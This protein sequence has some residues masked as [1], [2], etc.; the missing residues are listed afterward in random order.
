LWVIGYMLF[1]VWS[2]PGSRM[3]L[4][5]MLCILF[6]HLKYVHNRCSERVWF[7][8][9][10]WAL[11]RSYTEL[12]KPCVSDRRTWVH[13][14]DNQQSLVDAFSSCGNASLYKLH[15]QYYKRDPLR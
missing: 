8:L 6:F 3:Y 15:V 5:R 14:R 4:W 10:S 11:K 2:L 9:N 1:V 13:P 12:P 7:R